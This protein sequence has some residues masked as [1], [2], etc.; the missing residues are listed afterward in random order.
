[1]RQYVLY[2]IITLISST[3]NAQTEAIRGPYLQ[4]GTPTSVLIRWRTN[5]P[6]E[7]T[8]NFGTSLGNLNN[9][10]SNSTL[11]TEHEILLD[12]LTEN[13]T[14][15]YEISDMNGVYV[16]ESIDQYLK[17]P[18]LVG[19]KQFVRAW[20]LGDAGTGNLYQENVRD[21]YYDY[22]NNTISHPG[23]T[24]MMLFLG[25]NAY[26][27]GTDSEYQTGMFDVYHEQLKKSVA[28]ST[29]GNH[30]G[31]TAN[32]FTQ[33]GPYYDIFSLPKAGE[34]GG[35]PSG[36]EAYYSFDYANIHFIILESHQLYNDTTQMEW[37]TADIQST[38]QDWIVAIFHH[39]PYTKGSHNSDTEPE[40]I[41]MR[42]NFLPI[43]ESNGVD[44]V[45][46]GHSHSYE[47]SFYLNGH[48][49]KSYTFSGDRH[50]VGYNGC[51]SGKSDTEDNAYL[52]RETDTKG[53]VY[54]TTGSAGKISGGS[55]NHRAMYAS[56]NQ[57]GSCVLEVDSDG[58]IG[59]NLTVKFINDIGNISDYFTI[60]KTN[61]EVVGSDV[62]NKSVLKVYP[63]PVTTLLNIDLNGNDSIYTIRFFNAIGQ[64]IK[65][66]TNQVIDVSNLA[67]GTYFLEIISRKE[68]F[69]KK[70]IV[71]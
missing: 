17:T 28:W 36:T 18:P 32:S 4:I 54:I 51:L 8:V 24:D 46:S 16:T 14:Y 20:I 45:L 62:N 50:T 67:S 13:T 59:Q 64:L 3:L 25:D 49:G 9:T 57:L 27:N 26:D 43:L 6:T 58:N 65:E 7:S 55:L 56:L 60:H 12:G 39:P 35:I 23:Q 71:Q 22:V 2:F 11:N 1:M 48:Y 31:H 37:C 53:A 38:S 41:A 44:L 40:L 47:R 33:S 15:Y 21:A 52:K 61:A 19:D 70:I 29:L 5:M 34:A 42:E 63:V 68:K 66:D 69:Y 30:E 10:I